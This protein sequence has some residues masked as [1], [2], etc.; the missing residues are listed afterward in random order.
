MKEGILQKNQNI[1]ADEVYIESSWAGVV[2]GTAALIVF[3]A[4][5]TSIWK[6]EDETSV[7]AKQITPV[8]GTIAAGESPP[9]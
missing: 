2:L 6:K 9:E 1:R 4:A 5:R 3:A 8:A 7:A